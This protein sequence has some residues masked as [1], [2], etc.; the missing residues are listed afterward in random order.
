MNKYP[1]LFTPL[2]IRGNTYRNRIFSAPCAMTISGHTHTPDQMQMLYFEQKAMGG[3]A[4]VTISE[5]VISLKYGTRKNNTGNAAILAPDQM[6]NAQWI[7]EAFMINRHGAIPSVQLMHAGASTKPQFIEGRDPIG[8][9]D[10]VREDGVHVQGMDEALMQEI[11]DDWVKAAKFMK[12]CGFKHIMFHGGHGWLLAQFLSPIT[13]HRKDEY[14]GSIENRA[15]FPLRVIKAV[16]EAVGKDFVLEFRISG[17]EH[18]EGGITVEDVCA[19]AKMAED[20]LDI[21]HISAGS[22]YTSNLYMFPGIFVPYAC[23]REV[24]KAVKHSGTKI[25]VALVGALKDPA[26]MEEILESGDADIVYMSRQILA[27]PDVVNKW[28]AGREDDVVPCTR[29]MNCLGRFDKPEM[30]CDVN[31]NVG[32]ELLNMNN[33]KAPEASRNVLIIGGGPAGMKAAM[34]ASQRGHKVTLLE[35][36][37]E[38]GGT[39]NFLEHDCH[40]KDLMLFKNYL[41]RKVTED[42]NITIKFGVEATKE[43]IESYKPDFVICAV[44]S[45]AVVPPIPGLKENSRTAAQLYTYKGEIGDRVV[46]LGG[47]LSGV[48]MGLSYAEEGHHVTVIEM[49]DKLAA[50]ANHITGPHIEETIERLKANFTGLVN[51]KCVAV[52]ENGVEVEGPNGKEFI[53]ADFIVNALGQRPRTKVVEELCQADVPRFEVIGDAY[54]LAQVRGAIQ[55]GYFRALDIR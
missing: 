44:G 55:G 35:K 6:G 3:A 2:K 24:A 1:L 43:M 16:R 27:D 53:E 17:D 41:I 33:W 11:I 20:D 38:L 23:N 34:T 39:L 32:H 52:K 40:K 14:G 30:G 28:R 13:N 54:E 15:R 12:F 19:F 37:N 47:G 26:L 51:T 25:K 8:P 50:Q 18:I 31:P 29:C 10:Y 9:D 5:T 36:E 21:L 48:E 45:E 49:A 4:T 46:L 22:Y 42:N 7:K